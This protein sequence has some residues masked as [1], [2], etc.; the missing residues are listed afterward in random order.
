MSDGRDAAVKFRLSLAL[1]MFWLASCCCR[2]MPRPTHASQPYQWDFDGDPVHRP[3]PDWAPSGYGDVRAQTELLRDI[4]REILKRRAARA[5]ASGEESP[6]M[7]VRAQTE[8]LREMHREFLKRRAARALEHGHAS[9]QEAAPI[10][11]R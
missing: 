2:A 9:N 5:H 4:E 3:Q 11:A 1:G 7:D 10:P 6:S 8:L